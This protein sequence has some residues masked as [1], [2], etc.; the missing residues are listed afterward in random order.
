MNGSERSSGASP[1]SSS[2]DQAHPLPPGLPR[3]AGEAH[4]AGKNWKGEDSGLR[5]LGFNIFR[6]VNFILD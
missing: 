2:Q 1:P 6:K 5:F 4:L 3:H